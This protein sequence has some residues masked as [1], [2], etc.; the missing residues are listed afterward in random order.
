M[1]QG[2]SQLTGWARDGPAANAPV[3]GVALTRSEWQ[4]AA[5]GWIAKPGS[6]ED[7]L[8][9][10]FTDKN[11]ARLA[12]WISAWVCCLIIWWMVGVLK[13]SWRG[14]LLIPGFSLQVRS[15]CLSI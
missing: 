9:R 3:A 1:E 2:A 11:C 10:W 12:L 13:P 4:I 5:M 14:L 6:A 15:R 7:K 8:N